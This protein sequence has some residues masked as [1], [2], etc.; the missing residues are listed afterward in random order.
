MV[1]T[2]DGSLLRPQRG[3]DKD[4]KESERKG[5][6]EG[7]RDIYDIAPAYGRSGSLLTHVAAQMLQS[8]A[9]TPE[10]R[11]DADACLFGDLL[12]TLLFPVAKAHDLLL[13]G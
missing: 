10:G 2:L 7:R 3:G 5:K 6:R 9:H 12:E 8:V 13:L 4:G 11:I 1:L